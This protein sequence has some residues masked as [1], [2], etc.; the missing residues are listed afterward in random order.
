MSLLRIPVEVLVCTE[1]LQEK[2]A[3]P[4]TSE[5]PRLTPLQSITRHRAQQEEDEKD[6]IV[7]I[8]PG[9]SIGFTLFPGMG[10]LESMSFLLHAL[11]PP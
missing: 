2:Q 8:Q 3:T 11:P 6:P 7:L 5:P 4:L 1:P 10:I 9:P